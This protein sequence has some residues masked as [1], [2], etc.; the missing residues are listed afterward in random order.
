M[1]TTPRAPDDLEAILSQV[2]IDDGATT[3]TVG[4]SFDTMFTWNYAKGERPALDKLDEKAKTSQWNGTTDLDWSTD[5]DPERTAAELS[6]VDRAWA[7]EMYRYGTMFGFVYP[8][9][10]TGAL[11]IDDPRHVELTRALFRRSLAAI[12]ALDAFALPL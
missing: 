4:A 1:T 8:V 5:V 3:H 9:I 11:T 10:A 2:A 6:Q 12:D 7:R